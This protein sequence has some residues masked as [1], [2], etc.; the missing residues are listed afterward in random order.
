ME[1][2]LLESII[3][4]DYVIQIGNCT[5]LLQLNTLYYSADNSNSMFAIVEIVTSF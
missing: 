5:F 3:L 2:I 4:F 1:N